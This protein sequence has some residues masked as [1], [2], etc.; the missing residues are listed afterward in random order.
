M[1]KRKILSSLLA[2]SLLTPMLMSCAKKG[3][4]LT[5][6]EKDPWYD[7]VRFTLKTDQKPSE[8]LDSSIVSYSNGKVYHLYSLTNLADY[9][10][11]RR[12]ML[13]TYDDKGNELSTIKVKNPANYAIDRLISVKPDTGGKNLEAVVEVFSTGSFDTAVVIIDTES[14][15][16]SSPVFLQRKNGEALSVS[17]GGMDEY[18][19]SDVFVAGDY[20]IPVIYAGGDITELGAHAF[21]FKGPEYKAELD[22]SGIPTVN[23]I[24]GFSA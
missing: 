24:E 9:D 5:V 20:Y 8:M 6:S 3:N 13:T 7:S 16:C 23:M 10:N 21:T 14:G 17:A 1:L 2:V 12:T 11:Y 18:G 19:V 22:F 15:T 4:N